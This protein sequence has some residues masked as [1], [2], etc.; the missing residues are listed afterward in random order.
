M[1][2]LPPALLAQRASWS[3]PKCEFHFN[4]KNFKNEML[5][6]LLMNL[7]SLSG[8]FKGSVLSTVVSGEGGSKV[9]PVPN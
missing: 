5:S 9:P 2:S 8:A 6:E 3:T 7:Y 1:P 4:T